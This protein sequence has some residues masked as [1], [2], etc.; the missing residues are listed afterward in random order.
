MRSAETPGSGGPAALG[1]AH[2]PTGCSDRP[3]EPTG[4]SDRPADAMGCWDGPADP[5]GIAAAVGRT[6]TSAADETRPPAATLALVGPARVGSAV[7]Q[8]P[9]RWFAAASPPIPD[10]GRPRMSGQ[11]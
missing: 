4:C 7:T 11:D 8:A 10:V 2:T 9:P 5:A 3:A 1:S 6:G